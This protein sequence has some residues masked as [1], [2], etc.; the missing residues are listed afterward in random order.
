M[1]EVVF[2]SVQEKV[3]IEKVAQIA[4]ETW[5]EHYDDILEPNQIDY[6]IEK[7]QSTK[8]IVG[9]M[10]NENYRYILLHV[11]GTNVGYAAIH[12]EVRT[13]KLFLSKLY[14]LECFR[15]KGYASQTIQYLE[16]LCKDRDYGTIWLTVNKKNVNSIS[17]YEKKG[18]IKTRTQVTDIGEGYVMDDYIME[19]AI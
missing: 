17:T 19:K 13:K 4:D 14:I 8:A 9:Q 11:D 1:N 3:Q 18:F 5:H 10:I 12:E 15:G 7:F 2:V 16:K 6:M